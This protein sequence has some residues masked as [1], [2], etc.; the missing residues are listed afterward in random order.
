MTKIKKI[1]EIAQM[2]YRVFPCIEKI[3]TIKAWQINATRDERQI[4]EWFL[5][6]PYPYNVGMVCDDLIVIDVDPQGLSWLK[7]QNFDYKMP[8]Q[9]TPRGGFHLIF[10]KPENFHCKPSAGRV[11]EGVDVRTNGS[12]ILVEPSSRY[13]FLNPL[14]P[15]DQLSPPPQ[16]LLEQLLAVEQ[17]KLEGGEK[18]WEKK[19]FKEGERHSGLTSLAGKLRR[20]LQSDEEE[21]FLLL[22]GLNLT[23]CERPLPEKELRNIAHTVSRYPN[24]IEIGEEKEADPLQKVD[25]LLRS[26]FK[27]SVEHRIRA[28]K[29][30]KF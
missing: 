16:H 4:E 21:L 18:L 2:G 3:P 15:R 1:I 27:H 8:I 14:K 20:I 13:K 5:R 25:P 19:L 17:P 7:S 6:E 23:R 24:G 26:A 28:Y 29:Q 30:K 12:Y 22:K 9:Q 10:K 11:N